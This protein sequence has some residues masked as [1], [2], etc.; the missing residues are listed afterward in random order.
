MHA[1][2]G[3]Q[4]QSFSAPDYGDF[5]QTALVAEI[6]GHASG[7]FAQ[8]HQKSDLLPNNISITGDYSGRFPTFVGTGYSQG[9]AIANI[10][11]TVSDTVDVALNA[12]AGWVNNG[13]KFGAQDVKLTGP[14]TDIDFTM[15]VPGFQGSTTI[16]KS[17]S[18]TLAPGD[19]NLSVDLASLTASGTSQNYY[20]NF[21]VELVVPEPASLGV[22]FTAA[23]PFLL[24]LSRRTRARG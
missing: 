22:M 19:Y 3:D 15:T 11:F 13:G 8:Q 14:G 1:Q 24:S 16:N 10:S 17:Q 9:E 21:D 20:P 12:T 23:T 7:G 2:G 4:S 18:A 6:P 5:N